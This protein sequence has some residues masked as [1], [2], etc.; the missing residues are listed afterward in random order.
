MCKSVTT[1]G[2][3]FLLLC[4]LPQFTVV[5]GYLQPYKPLLANLTN[6]NNY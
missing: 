3:V 6:N 5:I 2:Y 4:H 1:A